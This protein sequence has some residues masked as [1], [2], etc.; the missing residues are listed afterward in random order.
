MRF[1]FG[2]KRKCAACSFGDLLSDIITENNLEKSFTIEELIAE[3][4]AIVGDIISTHSRPERIQRRMLVIAV[5]HS[6]YG[7]EIMLMKDMIVQRIGA[8]FPWIHI[9]NIRVD[10]KALRW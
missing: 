3:W 4:G 1:S 10:V 2:E 7:N 6:V 9:D 5:D 8:Q